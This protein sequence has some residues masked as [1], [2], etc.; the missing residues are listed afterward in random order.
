MNALP[1]HRRAINGRTFSSPWSAS[2]MD[3]IRA[4]TK[5]GISAIN[6]AIYGGLLVLLVMMAGVAYFGGA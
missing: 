3:P 2:S 4:Y 5:Q 1:E 6:R